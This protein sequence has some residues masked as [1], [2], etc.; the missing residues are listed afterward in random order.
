MTEVARGA[1]RV[2]GMELVIL[3]L[4]ELYEWDVE[5]FKKSKKGG[6]T[7]CRGSFENSNLFTI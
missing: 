3:C 4:R 7:I 1:K 6:S 5:V 2:S